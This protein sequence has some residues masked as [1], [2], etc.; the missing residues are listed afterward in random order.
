MD[1]LSPKSHAMRLWHRENAGVGFLDLWRDR[2]VEWVSHLSADEAASVIGERLED[3]PGRR[4]MIPRLGVDPGPRFVVL[5]R[6]GSASVEIYPKRYWRQNSWRPTLRGDLRPTPTG[7]VLNGI[8]S[9]P[10]S[11]KIITVLWLS[12]VAAGVLAAA[13]AA[14]TLLLLGNREDGLASLGAAAFLT[15]MFAFGLL[16]VVLGNAGGRSDE[17]Y[18]REWV[19]QQLG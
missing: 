2:R 15:V 7:S 18:L 14:L 4:E 1:G 12:V 9:Y 5:G 8:I 6:V 3:M 17:A 19:Q 16:F 11:L 10:R 13:I